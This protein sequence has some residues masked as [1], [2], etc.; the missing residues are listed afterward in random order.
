MMNWARQPARAAGSIQ[1]TGCATIHEKKFKFRSTGRFGGDRP[2]TVRNIRIFPRRITDIYRVST[3][4]A[5]KLSALTIA[6]IPFSDGAHVWPTGSNTPVI[7]E[8][9][10][11]YHL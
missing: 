10:G 1:S 2:D 9:L 8:E 5:T 6:I 3:L 4:T 7:L 11:V